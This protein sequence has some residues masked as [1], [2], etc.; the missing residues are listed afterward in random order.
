MITNS[1]L[2]ADSKLPASEFDTATRHLFLCVG[3]DCCDP[4]AH[5]A[6]WELLKTESKRLSVPI[7]RTKA[8]CLRICSDGPWLVVYPDGIWY[9]R[10][11]SVRLRRILKEHIEEGRPVQ[12]WIA[13]NMPA[14]G[15]GSNR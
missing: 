3:P 14:L 9:G 10:L 6:L 5:A 1:E 15:K 8:A 12:E 7:L 2:P 11:N 13:S 4:T